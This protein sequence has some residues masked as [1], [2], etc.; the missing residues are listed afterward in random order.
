MSCKSIKSVDDT[1]IYNL[2]STDIRLQQT[3][4]NFKNIKNIDLKFNF[5]PLHNN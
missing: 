2:A 4:Y 3:Y 1:A 5:T